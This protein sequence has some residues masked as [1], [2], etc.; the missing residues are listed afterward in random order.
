MIGTGTCTGK[1]TR[2]LLSSVA[3]MPTCMPFARFAKGKKGVVRYLEEELLD[4]CRQSITFQQDLLIS[5]WDTLGTLRE[6]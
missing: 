5:L 3:V 2:Q 1:T 4:F 6:L